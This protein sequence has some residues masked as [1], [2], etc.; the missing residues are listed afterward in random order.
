MSVYQL[1]SRF[2]N[3]LRPLVRSLAAQGVTA[4]QVTSVAAAVS[5]A[6]GL[7]LSVAPLPHWFLLVPVW[8]LLRMGLNAIDG[9]LA[10][11][12][13]QKSILGAYLNEIG[14][15]V[16]DV[17]LYVPFALIDP[18]G[19]MPAISVIFLSAL[20]E[21]T[22]ILGQTVGASRRYDGP[23]G[24]SDR[25]VLFGA[26]GIFVA[27]GGTFAAWTSWFWAVVALL[28]IWT[29]INRIR[30]GIREAQTSTR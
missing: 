16:S 14:D 12:H 18:N 2:Q 23:L 10:R 22:G 1:K 15:V 28:L 13:G 8:F 24:K 21:F 30:A 9:M 5:V 29:I 4:N 19:W 6:L 27:V 25:A 7:F 11:E 17:A 26:L 20:T 3:I